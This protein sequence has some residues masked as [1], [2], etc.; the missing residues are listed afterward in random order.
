MT[1]FAYKTPTHRRSCR[2]F[3]EWV[4][5]DCKW[6]PSQ[7]LCP[8]IKSQNNE[9]AA[10]RYKR[11]WTS[12]GCWNIPSKEQVSILSVFLP[13]WQNEHVFFTHILM[14]M[15][16]GLAY[17]RTFL[18]INALLAQQPIPPPETSGDCLEGVGWGYECRNIPTWVSLKRVDVYVD[19]CM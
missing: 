2:Q 17:Y 11:K 9:K 18:R 10:R 8:N 12:W 13:N 19:V 7:C 3:Q 15:E 1:A 6:P 14:T 5:H 4:I 16:P